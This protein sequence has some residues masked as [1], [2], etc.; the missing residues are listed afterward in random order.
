MV[1]PKG[2]LVN[3]AGTAARRAGVAG[4]CGAGPTAAARAWTEAVGGAVAVGLRGD[5]EKADPTMARAAAM[6]A[7]AA[8]EE[9]STEEEGEAAG[10]QEGDGESGSIPDYFR[11]WYRPKLNL[12]LIRVRR[13]PDPA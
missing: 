2:R 12:N 7:A 1:R 11:C 3:T 10:T 9:G 4:W 6:R 8:L 5:E 13:R